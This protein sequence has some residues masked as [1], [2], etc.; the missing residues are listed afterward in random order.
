MRLGSIISTHHG[1]HRKSRGLPTS[2][3]L[4]QECGAWNKKM[5]ASSE[6]SE[7]P[8][9]GPPTLQDDV[10]KRRRWSVK[11]VVFW[12]LSNESIYIRGVVT[13]FSGGSRGG[14]RYKYVNTCL[15]PIH[16]K[17]RGAASICAV[18]GGVGV[19][20]GGGG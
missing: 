6:A 5:S 15:P 12:R 13:F 18:E 14:L 10:I 3:A 16:S 17:G 1:P 20:V 19:E 8:P 7:W 4:Q 9:T 2:P 11:E